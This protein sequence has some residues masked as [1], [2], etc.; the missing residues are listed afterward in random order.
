MALPRTKVNILMNR[1]TS[2]HEDPLTAVSPRS[3]DPE[4]FVDDP[5]VFRQFYC[6][7]CGLLLENETARKD[8]PPLWDIQIFS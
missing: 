4:L 6:P 3:L 1:Y 7:S 5:M 8:D 2:Y